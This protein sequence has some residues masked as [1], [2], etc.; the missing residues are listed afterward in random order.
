MDESK[1]GMKKHLHCID[2]IGGVICFQHKM[3]GDYHY[4]EHIRFE[5][6]SLWEWTN[7]SDAK[8]S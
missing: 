2:F 5:V 6:P 1:K 7:R 4:F 3:N 8:E